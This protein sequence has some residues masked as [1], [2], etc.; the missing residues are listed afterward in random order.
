MTKRNMTAGEEH[1]V[2][3]IEE[4]RDRVSSLLLGQFREILAER[5][6]NLP[7]IYIDGVRVVEI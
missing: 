5:K 4:F 1:Y 7:S 2:F 3:G 6:I